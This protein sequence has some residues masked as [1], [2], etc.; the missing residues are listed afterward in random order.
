MEEQSVQNNAMMVHGN[1]ILTL[2]LQIPTAATTVLLVRDG[3]AGIHRLTHLLIV[4][5]YV[6]MVMISI[7]SVVM[8]GILKMEMVAIS[9][10]ELK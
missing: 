4:K 10:A 7:L 9:S 2:I 6:E 1:S 5:K 3:N 8:M